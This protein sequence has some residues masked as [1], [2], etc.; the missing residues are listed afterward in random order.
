MAGTAVKSAGSASEE[1]V[2][3]AS[4]D[5]CHGIPALALIGSRFETL[6][7]FMG[8]VSADQYLKNSTRL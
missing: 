8:C 6:P 5:E 7:Q 2:A 3:T 4:K 1:L